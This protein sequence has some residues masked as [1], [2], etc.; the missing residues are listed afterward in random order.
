[1]IIREKD[2]EKLQEFEHYGVKGMKWGVRKSISDIKESYNRNM[3]NYH[4]GRSIYYS[5][6]KRLYDYESKHKIVNRFNKF[7]SKKYD[8]LD[9][10]HLDIGRKYVS[11]LSSDKTKVQITVR[12]ISTPTGPYYWLGGKFVPIDK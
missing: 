4:D 12:Q 7:M 6:V 5:R 10:K 11:R 9:K 2:L 3:A 1:M 8:E